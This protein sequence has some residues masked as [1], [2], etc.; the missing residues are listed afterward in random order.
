MYDNSREVRFASKGA[1]KT[2]KRRSKGASTHDARSHRFFR[3]LYSH[4]AHSHPEDKLK[5][6]AQKMRFTKHRTG[7]QSSPAH[8]SDKLEWHGWLR[9]HK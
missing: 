8:A 9:R 3:T 7:S 6:W 2:A 1:K 5:N 4:S